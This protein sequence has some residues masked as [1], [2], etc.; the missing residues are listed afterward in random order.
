[1]LLVIILKSKR[2]ILFIY[3]LGSN[4]NQNEVEKEEKEEQEGVI[5]HISC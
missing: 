2:V 5:N 1:M 4:L 3:K